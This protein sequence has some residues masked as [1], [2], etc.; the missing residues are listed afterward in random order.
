MGAGQLLT[1]VTR[2]PRRQWM[3]Y[4]KR[5]HPIT[6]GGLVATWIAATS[7]SVLQVNSP[8]TRKILDSH[9]SEIETL[10]QFFK[11]RKATDQYIHA[12]FVHFNILIERENFLTEPEYRHDCQFV[13][14]DC[15]RIASEFEAFLEPTP[16][17]VE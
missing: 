3:A 4:L 2:W 7:E 10:K 5:R 14:K 11:E 8:K 16:K 12:C 6:W 15:S 17:R 13:V 9:I 1:K